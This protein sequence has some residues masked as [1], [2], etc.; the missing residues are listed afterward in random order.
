MGGDVRDVGV[1][2][3]IVAGDVRVVLLDSPSLFQ[4]QGIYGDEHGE[5]GDNDLRFGLLSASALRVA[6]TIWDGPPDVIHAHDWH[7]ALAIAYARLS[8]NEQWRKTVSVFTIHNLAFQG[9][10]P[11][12]RAAVLGLPQEALHEDAL[13]DGE[14]INLLK[15]GIVYADR[16]TTVSPSYAREV[17][18]PEHA[19]GLDRALNQR[20]NRLVGIVNGIDTDVWSPSRDRA[21]AAR[22]DAHDPSGRSACR[23]ALAAELGLDLSNDAPILGV[24]TRIIP[25]KGIDILLDALP[26]LVDMGLRL[27]IVA[28]GNSEVEAQLAD[29]AAKYPK[30]VAF[31]PVFGDPVARRIYAGCDIFVMPSRFEPCGLGQQYAMR[32]G[33]IPVVS[34]M[35]GMAD[36]VEQVNEDRETGTG[37]L[38]DELSADGLIAAVKR[39][40]AARSDKTLWAKLVRNCMLRDASWDVSARRYFAMYRELVGAPPRPSLPP[41]VPV[42]QDNES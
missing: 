22:Y 3:T 40:L 4:R 24:V 23:L 26:T 31:R 41:P 27:A 34:S 29:A 1:M 2:E 36:T 19:C 8:D 39:A 21:L 33:A 7:G 5:F 42:G 16:V 10:F 11:L 20:S 17:V 25:H 35:G 14:H 13:R 28:I 15:G 32:Y 6:E 37:F 12:E 38:F 18:K 30:K 9:T